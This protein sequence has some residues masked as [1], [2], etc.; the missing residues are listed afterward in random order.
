MLQPQQHQIR[1]TST[2]YTTALGNAGSL[3]HW[4][5]PGIE[6]ANLW[7]LVRF[8]NH[9]VRTGTSPNI[10]YIYDTKEQ[11]MTRMLNLKPKAIVRTP[12]AAKLLSTY[13]INGQVAF[14]GLGCYFWI[15]PIAC[16]SMQMI[17]FYLIHLW[18]NFF[19]LLLV[20]LGLYPR[21]MEVPR[22]GVELEL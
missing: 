10:I 9:W 12:N 14:T 22:L 19:S 3:T 15:F 13:M 5:K 1:A 2:T 21:H 6:P 16:Y 20:F 8:V 7:F 4:A 18:M 11:T 17:T